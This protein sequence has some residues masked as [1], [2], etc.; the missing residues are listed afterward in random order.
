MEIDKFRYNYGNSSPWYERKWMKNSRYLTGNG[1]GQR[2]A[3]LPGERADWLRHLHSDG[4]IGCRLFWWVADI[5]YTKVIFFPATK[6]YFYKDL[7][8][9][10]AE[11]RMLKKF[12]EW[13]SN[14]GPPR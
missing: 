4:L 13:D 11:N 6:P 5:M 10:N 8:P 2:P 9:E 14:R 12:L 3:I 7:Y 1:T